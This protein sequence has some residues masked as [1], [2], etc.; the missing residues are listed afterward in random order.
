[1]KKSYLFLLVLCIPFFSYSNVNM[2]NTSSNGTVINGRYMVE[3]FE[4]YSIGNSYTLNTSHDAGSTATIVASPTPVTGGNNACKLYANSS[5]LDY[6]LVNVNLPDGKVL[7]DC[8][9]LLLDLYVVSASYSNLRIW[10]NN[11]VAYTS[12][13]NI[14]NGTNVDKGTIKI[15][16]SAFT[17]TA[18]SGVGNN[19]TIGIG[20]DARRRTIDIDNVKLHGNFTTSSETLY[21]VTLNPGTGTCSQTNVT[22][23]AESSGVTLPSATPSVKCGTAG[24]TFAGWSQTVITETSTIPVLISAGAYTFTENKTLYA[25]YTNGT[26]YNSN[27]ECSVSL[28]G[29]MVG[30][31]LMIEDFENT[32]IG[33]SLQMTNIFGEAIVGSAVSA[34]NPTISEEKVAHITITSGNYN[35]LFKLSVTLPDDKVLADYE[36]LSFDLYR[37][38]ADANYKKMNIWIDGVKVYEDANYIQQAAIATWTTKAYDFTNLPAGNSFE[39]GLGISTD[40]GDYM[41]DN[42]KLLP[43]SSITTEIKNATINEIIRMPNGIGIISDRNKIIDIF[44]VKGQKIKTKLISVG[45]NIIPISEHGI[46]VVKIDDCRHKIFF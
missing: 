39:I 4:N 46:L 2:I 24:Y 36:K 6:I 14:I 25:V 41:I 10:I 31:W 17:Q 1:M 33:E 5:T 29:T 9:S 35:T 38:S 34:I 7:A 23:T 37:L 42:I 13:G 43:K 22:E 27:P 21:T 15:A 8:D 18:L 40:T 30:D 20:A 44:N 26:L 3:D 45:I 11:T 28:N 32:S 19:F 16:L 12:T